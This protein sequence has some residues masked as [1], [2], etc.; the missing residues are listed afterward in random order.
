M[1]DPR[2]PADPVLDIRVRWRVGQVF[3][4]A[5]AFFTLVA[6][7][8]PLAPW[9]PGWLKAADALLLG[10]GVTASALLASLRGRKLPET[11][12]LHAF[13]VLSVDALGQ[14]VGARGFPVW[15]FMALL[16]AAL[17]VAEPLKVALGVAGQATLLA[18]ADA[19]R[20]FFPPLAGGVAPPLDAKPALAAALGYF[21]LA[22]AVN[23]ALAGE[24]RRLSTTLAELA[25]LEHGID[26]LEDEPT[27]APAP[28]ASAAEALRQVTGEGRRARQLDRAS[29]LDAELQRL[30][31]V[32]RLAVDAHAVLYFDV[33]RQ[34]ELAHLRAARGPEELVRG[35]SVPLGADPFAFLLQR[36]QAFYATD[37]KRLLWELPWYRRQVKLGSL[38]A[39]PVRA[40]DV[41]VGALVADKVEVQAFT[42]KEPRLLDG[43][44]ALVADAIHR[45]RVSLGREELDAEFKAVYPLSQ[46]LATLSREADVR[47]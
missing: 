34:R 14:V 44:A 22:L 47:E 45:T 21:A 38:L 16:V 25:R 32:A 2:P 29:E 5:G 26:Q 35:G 4:A 10:L 36:G 43:F 31:E 19:A 28:P 8:R 39:V 33:D 6:L 11:L 3:L 15:P 37:F 40:G 13:L 1:A 20:P 7:V 42:G 9:S 27:G 23:R 17:A 46:R 41:I 12:A 24:K 18:V 30:V